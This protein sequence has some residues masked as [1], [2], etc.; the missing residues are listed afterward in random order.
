MGQDVKI[1]GRNELAD[2]GVN[3]K[4]STASVSSVGHIMTDGQL[5]DG[6]GDALTTDASSRAITTINYEHHEI[7]A[8]SHYFISSFGTFN[9]DAEAVFGI[10]TADTTEEIHITTHVRGTS[11]TELLIYED[12]TFTGGTPLTPINNNRN[13]SNT[14]NMTVV[15]APTVTDVGDLLGSSSTGKAGVNPLQAEGGNT[16]RFREIILKRNTLY[17]LKAISRDDGNIISYSAD[18]YEHT[19]KG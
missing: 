15:L 12:S 4:Y 17:I 19:P 7:H 9:E 11:Q 2:N 18:W 13:S 14:S 3:R 5:V 10:T 6:D 8:G 16:E 1:I